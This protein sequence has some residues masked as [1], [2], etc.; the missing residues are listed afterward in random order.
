M[1]LRVVAKW[2]SNGYFYSGRITRDL[3]E[4]RFGLRF[5]DGYECEVAGGDVLM[6]DPVPMET[7]VTALLEEE[8]FSVGVVKGYK[9]ESQEL[10][11]S[12]EREGQCQ[13]H[14]RSSVILS[15]EQG[16][17]LREQH[18]L[19]PY[20]PSTPLAKA[21]DISLDNLVEGKRRRRGGSGAQGGA[22]A[23]S[24]PRTPGPSGKRK[25]MSSTEEKSPAKR[26]RRGGG[27]CR[28]GTE[29]SSILNRPI[30]CSA[31]PLHAP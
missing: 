2:S 21:S 4:G 5:D 25:L 22:P 28:A 30:A 29:A 17:R 9:T 7:E 15:M 8:Y 20:Q 14:S 13:W 24:S 27:G 12:V 23:P 6:C 3:G 31:A 11:Y 1:G 10:Y 16:N 18:S 26:G 19:G